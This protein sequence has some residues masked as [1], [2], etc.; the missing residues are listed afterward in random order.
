MN[1]IIIGASSGI[2][3]SLAEY[4]LDK[5]HTLGITGR[6]IDLLENIKNENSSKNIFISKMDVA[7]AE[8]AIL[9]LEKLIIQMQGVDII[10]INAGV[11]FQKA[12]LQQELQT[13]DVN[14]RGFL[15]L[16]AWSYQYFKTKKSGKIVGISSVAAVRS[17]P[18][19]PEYHATK[20]FM[21]SYLEGLR[22]RSKKYKDGI[23]IIEIRPGFVDTEMTKGQK[24][25]FWVASPEKA[26][27]QIA[28]AIENN[29]AVAYV[30]RRYRLIGFIFK[31]TPAWILRHML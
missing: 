1:I 22:F 16:A 31:N 21:S 8:N 28:S 11:G 3:K 7:D 14:A 6:R 13:V 17:S 4:Y 24:G 10:V 26:A 29:K 12:T 27:D 19:S 15:V 20:A 2:G 25:M 18:Y 9:E 23:E 5:N 30:T